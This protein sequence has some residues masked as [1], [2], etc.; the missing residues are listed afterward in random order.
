MHISAI[1]SSSSF[2]D[3]DKLF[4][5]KNLIEFT[6]L[7]TLTEMIAL[8]ECWVKVRTFFICNKFLIQ[9]LQVNPFYATD[10]FWYPLKTT[11]NL[12]KDQWVPKEISGMKWV[13]TLGPTCGYL[14]DNKWIIFLTSIDLSDE[15]PWHCCEKHFGRE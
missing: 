13:K 5:V 9:R 6:Q 10:L 1:F 15:W 12:K 4:L 2:P 3:L 8:V 7:T 14:T 11:K